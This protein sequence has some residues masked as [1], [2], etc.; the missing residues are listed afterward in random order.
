MLPLVV[1]IAGQYARN[2]QKEADELISMALLGLSKA[3][4]NLDG[5]TNNN[6]KGFCIPKIHSACV[7]YDF[8][9][10][11]GPDDYRTRAKHVDSYNQVELNDRLLTNPKAGYTVA[12]VM[13]VVDVLDERERIVFDMIYQGWTLRDISSELGQSYDKIYRLWQVARRKIIRALEDA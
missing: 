13:E 5:M 4:N 2:N 11:F 12:D 7:H 8:K 6:L 1:C 9:K 10:A 3:L